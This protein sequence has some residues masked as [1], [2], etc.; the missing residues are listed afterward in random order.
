MEILLCLKPGS[1]LGSSTGALG[2]CPLTTPP[3]RLGN[4]S[5]LTQAGGSLWE[6]WPQPLQPPFPAAILGVCLPLGGGQ[7]WK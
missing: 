5:C 7:G 2:L 6:L 3:P 1:T 4:R